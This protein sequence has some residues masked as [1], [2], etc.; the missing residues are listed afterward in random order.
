MLCRTTIVLGVISCGFCGD[1]NFPPE[2]KFG[3]A[4]SAYQIEGA[5]NVSDKSESIW[6]TFTREHAD[7]ISD[8]SNGDIACDSYHLWRRDIEMLVELGVHFYRFSIS[9][10]RVLPTGFPNYISE[11]GVKYYNT[12]INALLENGIEPLVTLYHW[13]LPQRLQDL[14]G[15]TNPHIAEWFENYARTAFELFGDRVK[16][17]ITINEP[18]VVCDMAYNTGLVAPGIIDPEIAPYLCNKYTLMAHARAWRLYDKEFRHK[19]HGKISIANQLFWFQPLTEEDKEVTDLALENCVGR[20]SH[21]IY[22][23]KGGWPPSIEKTIH[24]NSRRQGY[25]KSN[26]PVLTKQEIEYIKG[27]YD[28]FGLNHYTSRLV[29]KAESGEKLSPWPTGDAPDFNARLLVSPHWPNTS[30]S[31]FFVNPPGIRK[32]LQWLKK[33][34]G[35][36][37]VLVTENGFPNLGGVEDVDRIN[38]YRDN[39]HEILLAIKKDKINVTAYTAW[40]LMDNYEWMDGYKSKF[41]LYHVDFTSPQRTRTPK[42]SAEYYKSVIKAHSLKVPHII[43]INNPSSGSRHHASSL[44]HTTLLCLILVNLAF[45]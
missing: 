15:W 14:G 37:T 3:V 5:W 24:D 36:L 35:D 43:R 10:P 28:F 38:Y 32:L 31:W 4:S 12:L 30:S 29:R 40:T 45:Y 9:W 16:T 22:S 7:I 1:L 33:N 25:L 27:T 20:Y 8:R 11:D 17:W 21:P 23:K 34:Y 2:F 41:G 6:D 39:M 19:Y 44:L 42:A 26:L 13:D 18:F